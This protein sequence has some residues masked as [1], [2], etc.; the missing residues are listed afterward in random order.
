MPRKKRQASTFNLSFLDIM[1]CGFGA[2][3]LVF[4]IIDHSMEVESKTLNA[5]VLSEINLLDEDIRE[6]EAGLVRLRNALEG[7][8]DDIVETQGRA[9]RVTE[10][11]DDYE[12]LIASLEADGYTTDD[13]VEALKAEVNR[14]QEEVKKLQE[15]AD[16]EAGRSA[17]EF[18]G[19]GNRQYLTGLN[20]GGNHIAILVDTSASMLSD[21]LVNVIRLRNMQ[22]NVQR[23]AAKWVRTLDTI[24]WL[25]A[26][27]PI[28]ARIQLIGFNT[29]TTFLNDQG[30]GQWLEVADTPRLEAATQALRATLPAGGTSLHNAFDALGQLTPSPDN[31]FLITDGLP[32]QGDSPPNSTTVS[33]NDRLRLFR[34]AVRKLPQGVPVNIVLAPMEGDP[35]AASEFWQ[36]AGVTGGSFMSPSSDWP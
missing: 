13:D 17:R 20:L 4:L 35:M 8:D 32:T 30:P 9:R 33:G 10:E 12:A 31:I 3:V 22:E 21:Q 25:T 7:I 26:Q 28:N 36:L 2:V 16:S 11:I 29:K 23:E 14:L 15:A 34:Q 5:E 1:S 18:V 24:D 19:E 6:G 27:L